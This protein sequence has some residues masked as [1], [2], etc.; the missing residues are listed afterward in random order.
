[1][2]IAARGS[3]RVYLHVI[4]PE[5]IESAT[6]PESGNSDRRAVYPY[7]AGMRK[8]D[9]VMT[10]IGMWGWLFHIRDTD[11]SVETERVSILENL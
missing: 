4:Q 8:L 6:H 7:G 1:M 5:Y 3:F 11:F 2:P 9:L 10:D